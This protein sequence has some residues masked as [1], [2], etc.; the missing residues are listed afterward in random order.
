MEILTSTN[1][2]GNML[3]LWM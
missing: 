2:H 1:L 3:S